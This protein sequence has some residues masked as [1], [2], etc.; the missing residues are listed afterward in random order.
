MFLIFESSCF[1]EFSDAGK[2]CTRKVLIH[3]YMCQ[4]RWNFL[5]PRAFRKP[6]LKFNTLQG[7][8]WTGS[9]SR[10]LPRE[11]NDWLGR[12]GLSTW[13]AKR[14][15]LCF[16]LAFLKNHLFV[17]FGLCG[18]L[19]AVRA[20]LQLWKEGATLHCGVWVSHCS[21]FS[22][23]R[24]LAV[25]HVGSIVIAPG[26]QSKGL[27]LVANE[28]SC[29]EACGIILDQGTNPYLLPWQED[30]LPLSHLGSPRRKGSI[31]K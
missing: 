25:G 21:G 23:C 5:L 26:L 17:C 18:V 14:G 12:Q 29:S 2:E 4:N 13:C 16:L 1:E 28:L 3:P 19:V 6:L 7:I 30:S 24:V 8:F 11:E 20:F 31:Y 9:Q 10:L 27:I 15:E 22:C